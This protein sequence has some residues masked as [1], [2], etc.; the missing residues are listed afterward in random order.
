MGEIT[1]EGIDGM[2]NNKPETGNTADLRDDASVD[3]TQG[4]FRTVQNKHHIY[5]NQHYWYIHLGVPRFVEFGSNIFEFIDS[6]FVDG[7]HRQR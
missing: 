4:T 3:P 2:E 6:L 1:A 7:E 5:N